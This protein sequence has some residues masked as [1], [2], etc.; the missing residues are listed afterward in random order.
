MNPFNWVG[1]NPTTLSLHYMGGVATI[2]KVDDEWR[3][4]LLGVSSTGWRGLTLDEIR[5]RTEIMVARRLIQ[6]A[7]ALLA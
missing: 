3:V 7:D 5:V 1:T 4:T 2:S 6:M